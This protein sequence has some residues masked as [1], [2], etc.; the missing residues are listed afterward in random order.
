MSA[1]SNNPCSSRGLLRSQHTFV[2]PQFARLKLFVASLPQLFAD[3]EQGRV[4]YRGR[5]ELREFEVEGVR[6]VVKSFCKPHLVNRLAYGLLRKSKA[7]RSF[8]YADLLRNEGIGS[9]A[10]VG[11]V[12]VRCG[13]LLAESY[14]VSVSSDLPFTYIDLMQPGRVP[15]EEILLREVG[16]TAGRMH[17]LGMIHRDFSRGNILVGMKE[18][19]PCV[20][21]IDLNRIRFHQINMAEGLANFNRLP[22]SDMMRR[23]LAEGY[24]ETRGYD[25]A[26]CQT[27]WPET[28][29]LDSPAAGNRT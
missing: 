25:A 23:L 1:S 5:N 7:Q 9:P 15:G 24:A 16:R 6:V 18:G 10:P 14:Y 27:N 11:W 4:I 17:N 8:E 21:I 28:E 22:V 2:H 13:L 26:Q 12:T 19:K 3:P 29:S 20:E